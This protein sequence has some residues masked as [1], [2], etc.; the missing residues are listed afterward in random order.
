MDWYSLLIEYLL[1]VHLTVFGTISVGA[2]F[3]WWNWDYYKSTGKLDRMK[4]KQEYIMSSAGLVTNATADFILMHW[5]VPK[6]PSWDELSYTYIILGIIIHVLMADFG[7]FFGHWL[8]HKVR[9]LRPMHLPWH[10]MFVEPSIVGFAANHPFENVCLLLGMRTCVFIYP[11]PVGWIIFQS[12]ASELWTMWGH[13]NVETPQW[14]KG[15][16]QSRWILTSQSHLIHHHKIVYNMGL[17]FTFWDRMF[18]TYRHSDD[19][20]KKREPE[21]KVSC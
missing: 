9:I 20:I 5:L 15:L 3:T 16:N 12:I 13:S 19:L 2:L 11:M 18:G 4:L 1:V 8:F 14:L 6:P 7:I 21:T 17:L 10:H